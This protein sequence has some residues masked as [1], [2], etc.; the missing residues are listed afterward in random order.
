[1]APPSLPQPLHPLPAA[2][3]SV[4]PSGAEHPGRPSETSCSTQ[5]PGGGHPGRLPGPQGPDR[6]ASGARPAQRNHAFGLPATPAS[7]GLA[8]RHVRELLTSWSGGDEIRDNAVVVTSELVTNALTHAAGEWIVCR[9]HIA[10]GRLRI[11]VEDESRGATLPVPRQPGPD[12]QN[13]RGL[14][15]VD[16][17]SGAWGTADAPHGSGRVVWAE[18]TTD[19]YEPGP[20]A[21]PPTVPSTRPVPHSAEGPSPHA[22]TAHP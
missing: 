13:G 9:L 16:A 20:T 11:E 19:P 15:L 14:L 3:R 6:L 12:E 21:S 5:P 17:L 8:R 18:L 22:P 7:V 10:A 1:M 2:Q 4:R